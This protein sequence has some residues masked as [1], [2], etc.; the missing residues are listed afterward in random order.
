MDPELVAKKLEYEAKKA[1]LK[2]LRMRLTCTICGA[3][4]K[5]YCSTDC[6]R[7][8]WRDRGHRK[9]CKK[10]RADRAAEAA[11]A[12]APTPLPSPPREV[13]YGPAPRSQADEIRARI[14][15]EHEA[16][17]ARREANPEPEPTSARAAAALAP[18]VAVNARRRDDRRGDDV[19]VSRQSVRARAR[20]ARG[21][22][23]DERR[24]VGRVLA[25]AL[26]D[27]HGD[28]HE[29]A[30]HARE[31]A[32][33]AGDEAPLQATTYRIYNVAVPFEA[34][35]GASASSEEVSAGL[36]A[37]TRQQVKKL[38]EKGK[39]KKQKRATLRSVRH[40][41]RKSLDARHR[42]PEP[43]WVY[44]ADAARG[45]GFDVTVLE[46]GEPVEVRGR[47]IGRLAAR[48]SLV[49]ESN[50]CFGEAARHVVRRETDD[51]SAGT[52][53]TSA[54]LRT[55][56]FHGAPRRS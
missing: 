48:R 23:A 22:D 7:I 13:V 17:R 54:V 8:D 52:P 44:A 18:K 46:R 28:G 31:A 27:H 24:A 42:L 47:D 9:A 53:K 38:Q 49:E 37:A 16:A 41:V 40:V 55:L 33:A 34:D 1:R 30:A 45:D 26:R 39:K 10:I 4:P 6:Q 3:K 51:E 5:T 29:A 50:F 32:E 12:E 56:V 11:R 14:A 25:Q 15:A 35:P 2:E 21:Q 36:V 43:L 20:G 19:D